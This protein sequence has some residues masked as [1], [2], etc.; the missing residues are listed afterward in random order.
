VAS[1]VLDPHQHWFAYQEPKDPSP[2]R[3]GAD[4]PSL[5][6]GN[7]S[8]DEIDKLVACADHPQSPVAGIGD[9]HGQVDDPLQDHGQRQLG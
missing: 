1:D 9:L 5:L 7:P 2:S 8:R 3:Q 6:G 4:G